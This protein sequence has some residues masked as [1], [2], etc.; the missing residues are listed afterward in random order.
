MHYLMSCA[1][2]QWT[3]GRG[4]TSAPLALDL[5]ICSLTALEGLL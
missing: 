4:S 2:R 5:R 3:R 1:S